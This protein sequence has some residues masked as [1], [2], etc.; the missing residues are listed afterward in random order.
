[1]DDHL[2]T[3]FSNVRKWEY[4]ALIKDIQLGG[5]KEQCDTEVWTDYKVFMRVKLIDKKSVGIIIEIDWE[6]AWVLLDSGE[7]KWIKVSDIMQWMNP[8]ESKPN[9]DAE[10]TCI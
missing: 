3:F 10:G 2:V 7:T 1:M 9:L 5:E 6:S 4:K 8:K